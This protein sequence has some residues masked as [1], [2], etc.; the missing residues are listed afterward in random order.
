MQGRAVAGW[1]V[2]RMHGAGGGAPSGPANGRWRHGERT[3]SAG[4]FRREIGDL[5]AEARK[6]AL[7]LGGC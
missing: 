4:A 5:V 3:K 6:A 7:T 2:C 1:H